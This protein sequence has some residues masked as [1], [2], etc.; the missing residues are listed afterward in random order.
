MMN[1]IVCSSVVTP[2]L[3]LILLTSVGLAVSSNVLAQD[4]NAV[5][6]SE[7][8][9]TTESAGPAGSGEDVDVVHDSLR[10]LKREVE[11]AINESNWEGL[12]Q[13]L[14][15]NVIVTWI[16]GT[17]SH[18]RPDVLEYMKSKTEGDSPIVESFAVSVQVEDLSDLYGDATA[19]AFGSATCEFVLRGKP[20]SVTG[21]WSATVVRENNAWKLAQVH[22]SVGV[23]DN[24]LLQWAWR[25]AWIGCGV[26]GLLGCVVGWFLGRR[27]AKA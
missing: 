17:Q 5:A 10:E 22:A 20:M 8:A 4:T 27:S 15:D 2:V 3:T 6:A 24:P 1:K 7:E 19:T 16:D 9:A 11:A 12:T 23:F 21:P 25:F 18:G 14:T 13:S 26:A